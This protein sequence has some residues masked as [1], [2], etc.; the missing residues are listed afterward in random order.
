VRRS[1]SFLLYSLCFLYLSPAGVAAPASSSGTVPNAPQYSALPLSFEPNQGQAEATADFL[2]RGRGYAIFL[3]SDGAVL[4]LRNLAAGTNVRQGDSHPANRAAGQRPVPQNAGA[5]E[6]DS[7]LRLRLVGALSHPVTQAEDRLPGKANYFLGNDPR[8]WHTNI[9]TFGKVRYEG[10]YPGIDLV[11]YGNQGGQLEYDFV[12]Q[13]G[14]DPRLIALGVEAE[15]LTEK[16]ERT[17][18][19]SPAKAAGLSVDPAGDLVVHLKDGDVRFHKPVI[20]QVADEQQAA[21]L[22][23]VVQGRYVLTAASQVHFELGPYDHTKPL[24]IDP[25]LSYSTYLGGTGADLGYGVAV[26]TAG[27]AYVTGTTVS[28]NFPIASGGVQ[29]SYGGSG[30]VFL[31]KFNSAGSGL[32]FSTYLGGSGADT[33]Y[34]I[35]L[36]SAGNIYLA[37]TTYSANFPTTTG[38]FQTTYGGNGDVFVAKL[39][40]TGSALTYATYLGGSSADY[41]TALALDGAGDVFVTGSTQSKDFPTYNPLQLGNVGVSNVFVAE[42]NPTGTALLYSTYLGGSSTDYGTAI[43]LDDAGDV[44]LCGYTFSTDFPTQNAY[45]SSLQGGSDVFVTELKPGSSALL[46]STFLGGSSIDRA[47]A[48]AMDSAGSIYVAGDTQSTNF[49]LT[50]NAYQSVNNGSGDA[51]VTKL[52]P[53]GGSLVYSTL[54]G[55]SGT[56]QISAL[57]LDSAGD[58]YVTGFTQSSSFPL[59]DAF[60]KILG[61]S[62]A[63]SCGLAS[64]LVVTCSDAFVAKLGPSGSLSYSTLLGGSDADAGQA[65]VVDSEGTAYVVG[66]ATSSNFPATPG[67]FQWAY[68][69]SSATSNA[70]LAK[71][72]SADAA[73]LT[74]TPQQINFGNQPLSTTSDPTSVTLVNEGSASLYIDSITASGS[75]A[76]TN[77]CG[78]QL[79]AGGSTCT[80]KVTFSPSVAGTQT[81]QVTINDS[82]AGSPHYITIT[83]NG[84]LA[85]GSLSVTPSSLSFPAQA[86]STTSS[87]QSILLVNDGSVAVTISKIAI[88]GNYAQTNTCGGLPTTPDVLNVGQSCTISITF[89]PTGSGTESGSLTIT[90]DA[91]N[92]TSSVALSGIG[93]PQFSLSANSRSN[94]IVVGT[95]STTFGISVAAPSSFTS[96]VTLACSSG[97][98]CA[99][100]PASVAAGGASTLT[101]SGLS[102]TTA[103]PLSFTITGTSG[104]QKATLT[105]AIFLADYSLALT[106]SSTSVAAGNDAT[107]TITVTPTNGFGEVVF[108]SCGSNPSGT[109]CTF[110]PPSLSFAGSTASLTSV[111]TVTT[112]E[113]SRI[114]PRGPVVRPP[115]FLPFVLVAMLLLLVG[116]AGAVVLGHRLRP[117]FKLALLVLAFVVVGFAVACDNYVNPIN[118]SPVVNGTPS[119]NYKIPI[120]GTL[121]TNSKVV[122]GAIAHLTVTP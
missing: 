25:V 77:N 14:A 122:R 110:V 17:S 88:S 38:A 18:P 36:D 116:T 30:D 75:A 101:V 1:R 72:G 89:T 82:A 83:G 54:L 51:F 42:L 48:M 91:A 108:L 79:S 104:T 102:S 10:V 96:N 90:S 6:A 78:T 103:N 39:D 33:A 24:V 84:V 57:A 28:A 109:K 13:P 76:Q 67:A 63:G 87:P 71:I 16:Q 58:V 64:Q 114:Y 35:Q 5:Q 43:A 121:A 50:S 118:I 37:G 111:L 99:F 119:G 120:L 80:V 8:Q 23:T 44:Y 47:F 22:R 15:Q 86:V 113:Q 81:D 66:S 93:T 53:G 105:L 21:A 60:Q 31:T 9:A 49:P 26:D 100:S 98:T 11:Y 68:G 70:F 29:T 56:D 69:G 61:I 27:Q 19:A 34:A 32:V 92:T 45:Q 65:I 20:Y 97:A 2:A 41:G 117:Q 74:L 12:V 112:T 59:L 46:F 62:G 3:T 55:G 107:Y 4:R 95:T 73:A 85:G 7:I 106:P 115:R 40:S 52:A 94:V